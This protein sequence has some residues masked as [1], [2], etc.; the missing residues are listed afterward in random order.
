MSRPPQYDNGAYGADG[1]AGAQ[2]TDADGAPRDAPNV[3]LPLPESTPPYEAYVD[4]AAA[5]GW[6]NAY[7]ETAELPPVADA[8][9]VP[10]G[11]PVVGAELVP[12]HGAGQGRRSRRKPSRWRSRR[13]VVAAGAVG[14]VSLAALIAGL[15]ISG[16][17]SDGPQGKEGAKSAPDA[18]T[19]SAGSSSS[20]GSAS[21]GS[22]YV[23]GPGGV[24]SGGPGAS[25]SASSGEEKSREP[26]A[27]PST[28]PA[29][30]TSP[31]A[32]STGDSAP[33]N[34]EGKGHGARSTKGPK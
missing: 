30:I 1:T 26:S 3:Y 11:G 17:S 29:T 32:T 10:V 15:S 14:A 19:G 22:P 33:G 4:P 21:S 7:D 18:S 27:A 20:E 5:H 25:K 31:T 34:S 23:A 16:S 24:A 6:Q 2:G 8:G 28:G 13:L 9:P 12:A